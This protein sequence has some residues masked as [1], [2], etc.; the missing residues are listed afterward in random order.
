MITQHNFEDTA[1]ELGATITSMVYP[2]ISN[3]S[4][5]VIGRASFKDI[6]NAESFSELCNESRVVERSEVLPSND[7]TTRFL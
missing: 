3:R 7:V 1:I 6:A 5:C 2:P 4:A